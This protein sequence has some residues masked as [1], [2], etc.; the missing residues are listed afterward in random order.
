MALAGQLGPG[1]SEQWENL[2]S[3]GC[4]AGAGNGQ[5]RK[6]WEELAKSLAQSTEIGA[7]GGTQLLLWP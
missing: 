1:R 7:G 4:G 3:A 2:R 6:D 5:S